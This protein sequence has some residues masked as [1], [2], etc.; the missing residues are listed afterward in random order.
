MRMNFIPYW[1]FFSHH[2]KSEQQAQK[3][4]D[5]YSDSNFSKQNCDG[6]YLNLDLES[7]YHK[8]FNM[9]APFYVCVIP[10]SLHSTDYLCWSWGS[11]IGDY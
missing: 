10:A 6:K 9:S 3:W 5:C 7:A 2:K 8:Q 1:N 4:K 11:Y